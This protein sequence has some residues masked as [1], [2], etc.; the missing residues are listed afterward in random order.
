MDGTTKVTMK[1]HGTM[2]APDFQVVTEYYW[3]LVCV[4]VLCNSDDITVMTSYQADL[5]HR[6]VRKLSSDWLEGPRWRL[7]II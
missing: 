6:C 1:P 2:F 5:L 3:A 7:T 4:C